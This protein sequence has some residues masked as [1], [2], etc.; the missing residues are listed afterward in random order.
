MKG[1]TTGCPS[2]QSTPHLATKKEKNKQNRRVPSHINELDVVVT[3]F[4]TAVMRFGKSARGLFVQKR[5]F[6]P[7]SNDRDIIEY[8]AIFCRPRNSSYTSASKKEFERRKRQTT[9]AACRSKCPM[10]TSLFKTA[11][12]FPMVSP[13]KVIRPLNYWS[14]LH[15]TSGSRALRML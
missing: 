11:I 4:K 14:E 7:I 10:T 3:K 1:Q 8:Q 15:E 5:I 2:L 9:L 12:D 6:T 13:T